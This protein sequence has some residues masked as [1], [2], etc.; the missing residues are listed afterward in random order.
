MKKPLDYHPGMQFPA[1]QRYTASGMVYVV[2][3]NVWI[4]GFLIPA[5]FEFDGN[6][7]PR[8]LY[9]LIARDDCLAAACLHD[10]IYRGPGQLVLRANGVSHKHARLYA[11]LLW[12][13]VRAA[14]G[15]S[16]V[17]STIGYIGLRAFGHRNFRRI[18]LKKA[19]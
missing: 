5:G 6:S 8:W 7:A 12:F 10:F 15:E 17:R 18:P 16:P 2:T 13:S 14:H 1:K 3:E 9:W 19:A 4:C 11:D